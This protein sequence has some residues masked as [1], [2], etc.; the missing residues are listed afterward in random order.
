MVKPTRYV[1]VNGR[2]L[3]VTNT[4]IA[5]GNRLPVVMREIKAAE[6]QNPNAAWTLYER[7]PAG[8]LGVACRE[9]APFPGKWELEATR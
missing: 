6:Q 1:A 7:V 2:G 8:P 9:L 5:S 4:V 3:H